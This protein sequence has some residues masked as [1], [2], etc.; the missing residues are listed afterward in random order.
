M[1]PAKPIKGFVK[2]RAKSVQDQLSGKEKGEVMDGGF[3]GPGGRGGRFGPGNFVAPAFLAKLDSDKSGGVS[4]EEFVRGFEGWF[5]QWDKQKGGSLTEDEL[6]AGLNETF[7]PPPG[8]PGGFGGPGPVI[9]PLGTG[10][11]PE[12][13]P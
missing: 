7:A 2:V 8:G 11:R 3:G 1:Q 5:D 13:K 9:R 12:P 10:P 6:R 4:R